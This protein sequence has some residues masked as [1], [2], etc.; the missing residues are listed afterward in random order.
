MRTRPERN[1]QEMA[2]YI[3]VLFLVIVAQGR[4]YIGE[5]GRPLGEQLWEEGHLGKYKLAQH[6]YEGWN[7]TRFVSYQG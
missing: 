4:R 3:C 2:C 1:L 7:E 6:V 5:T